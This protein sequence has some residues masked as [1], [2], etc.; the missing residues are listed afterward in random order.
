MFGISFVYVVFEDGTDLYWARSRVLEYLNGVRDK[1]PAG[2]RC[3]CSAPTRP[4]SV[5]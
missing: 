5:G 4:A 3:R 2:A 1:L